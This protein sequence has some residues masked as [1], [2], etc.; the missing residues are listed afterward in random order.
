MNLATLWTDHL[1]DQ[2]AKDNFSQLVINH[3]NDLVLMKLKQIIQKK[4]DSLAISE[5]DLKMYNRANWPYMM[6]DNNGAIR[7]L[8]QVETLL[9]FVKDLK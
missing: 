8:K 5:R 7:A 3:S 6:A 1:K 4:L 2:E 9:E